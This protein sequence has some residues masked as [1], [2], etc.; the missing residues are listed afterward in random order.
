MK[1]GIFNNAV[2]VTF[3]GSTSVD[4]INHDKVQFIQDVIEKM[5]TQENI[6]GYAHNSTRH[7]I[8][9]RSLVVEWT[10][11]I[12]DQYELEEDI[13][14]IAI[15]YY[16][17]FMAKQRGLG[18]DDVGAINLM[19]LCSLQLAVK[20]HVPL[21]RKK[22]K[23]LVALSS[24]MFD[25]ATILEGEFQLL[26]T[27]SWRVHPPTA[28]SFIVY[29]MMLIN[30]AL[31]GIAQNISIGAIAT[32]ASAHLKLQVKKHDLATTNPSV[33]AVTS[34]LHAVDCLSLAADPNGLKSYEL[35][36]KF[37]FCLFPSFAGQLNGP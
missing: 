32:L 1:Q 17:R 30:H 26:K 19:A 9:Q 25:A 3:T 4:V 21:S 8:L 12:V 10:F 34:I 18:L 20:V 28:M 11:Q 22:S 7:D 13:A 2:A 33:M 31:P 35:L 37:I 29:L 14:T 16:D 6:Y 27:L 36:T 24:S 5:L 15:S 23:A